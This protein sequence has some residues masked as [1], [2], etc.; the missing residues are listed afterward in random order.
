MEL[1]VL[2]PIKNPSR[3]FKSIEEFDAF[4]QKNKEE[5]NAKTTQQLNKLYRIVDNGEEY[6]ITKKGTRDENGKRTIGEICIKKKS[7][8]KAEETELKVEM[9]ELIGE[10]NAKIDKIKIENTILKTNIDALKNKFEELSDYVNQAIGIINK[11]I[12]QIE[13]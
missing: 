6:K 2:D 12:T 5:L 8:C 9:L 1:K 3:E 11:R 4:F 10:L 7:V 13:E